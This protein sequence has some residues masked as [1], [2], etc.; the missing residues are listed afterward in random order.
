MNPW[1]SVFIFLIA[2]ILLNEF[3]RLNK[4]TGILMYIVLPT[5]LFFTSYYSNIKD[6]MYP[7][8][9]IAKTYS[10]L[11]GCVGFLAIRYWDKAKNSSFRM[12]FPPLILAINIL[13]AVVSDFQAFSRPDGFQYALQIIH[14]GPYNIMNAIAGILNILTICGW[15]GICVSK[16]KK[17]DMLWPDM[18]WFWI[19]A[20]DIWNYCYT[21]QWGDSPYS[22]L[23]LLLSCTIPTFLWS[24]GAWLENRASTLG[25]FMTIAMIDPTYCSWEN[26]LL[27]LPYLPNETL[28]YV[29]ASLSLAANIAVFVYQLCVI[30]RKKLNPLKDELYTDTT[31]YKAVKALAE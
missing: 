28:Y 20:Y 29:V 1:I 7:W 31:A 4:W 23:A 24:K 15:V 8:F 30:R 17:K 14:G 19:I 9:T 16:G 6:G 3:A 2:L 26:T 22:G 13:E 10:A 5:V 11:A 18:L 27:P 21:L 12:W 25:I